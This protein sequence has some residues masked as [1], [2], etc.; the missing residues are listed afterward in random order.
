MLLIGL[1][2][3]I[4][5][6]S[7]AAASGVL[8]VDD[9][10]GCGE[11]GDDAKGVLRSM[12]SVVAMSRRRTRGCGRCRRAR[13]WPGEAPVRHGQDLSKFLEIYY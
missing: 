7:M 3:R 4:A 8:V 6:G 11:A 2:G 10:T 12:P 5:M 9:I 1:I 13:A